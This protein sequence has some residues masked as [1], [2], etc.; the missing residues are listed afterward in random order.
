[1]PGPACR[2]AADR[3]STR[4]NV[5]SSRSQPP[6]Y[7]ISSCSRM[8]SAPTSDEPRVRPGQRRTQACRVVA[9][10][11]GHP[12]QAGVAAPHRGPQQ[13]GRH[14]DERVAEVSEHDV[15][16]PFAACAWSKVIG[17]RRGS[18]PSRSSFSSRP[19]VARAH[20]LGQRRHLVQALGELALVKARASSGCSPSSS[21][22]VSTRR[23]TWSGV[24]FSSSTVASRSR[25]RLSHLLRHVGCRRRAG[26]FASVRLPAGAAFSTS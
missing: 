24:I 18:S 20:V 3:L 9:D 6:A 14:V 22:A 17:R 7:R 25:R 11:G 13:P 8:P 19:S 1:M 26:R 4:R 12:V 21:S 15:V 2:R 10:H 23:L 16:P 5:P